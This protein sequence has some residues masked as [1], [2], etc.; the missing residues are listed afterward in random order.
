MSRGIALS[1]AASS[2]PAEAAGDDPG[3]D[4]Q[5]AWHRGLALTSAALLTLQLGSGTGLLEGL[6]A[7]ENVGDLRALHRTVGI[8][9]TLAYGGS[10]AFALTAPEAEASEPP[11]G[12]LHD[13]LVWVTAVGMLAAPGLG[14]YMAHGDV[15][16]SDRDSLMLTHRVVGV[17]TTLALWTMVVADWLE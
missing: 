7:S 4:D 1:C 14:L 12:T 16:A 3:R 5:L 2:S 11:P 17:T 9:A 15:A 10:V 13:A 6:E 8:G